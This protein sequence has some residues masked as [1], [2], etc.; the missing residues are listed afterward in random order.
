MC[1]FNRQHAKR[2]IVSKRNPLKGW[3]VL[4]RRAGG[5]QSPMYSG[6]VGSKM[7]SKAWTR[8]N[9]HGY[10]VMKTRALAQSAYCPN[11]EL[12]ECIKRVEI[13]GKIREYVT[14]YRAEWMRV[15]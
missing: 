4:R 11:P 5:W 6:A 9:S 8:A 12:G 7:D 2:R 15:L 1:Y 13:A 10:Y 14:G 3:K